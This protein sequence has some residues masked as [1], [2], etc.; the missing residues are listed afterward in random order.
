MG[1][2]FKDERTLKLL[3]LCGIGTREGY[4]FNPEYEEKILN[5]DMEAFD[6]WRLNLFFIDLFS[7][8]KE[9]TSITLDTMKYL[10]SHF[11]NMIEEEPPKLFRVEPKIT[12]LLT[13]TK[14]LLKSKLNP[15]FNSFFLDCD[16]KIKIR[17]QTARIFGMFV[18]FVSVEEME[19]INEKVQGILSDKEIK[20]KIQDRLNISA[21]VYKD[22]VFLFQKLKYD[23]FTGKELNELNILISALDKSDYNKIRRI[24]KEI[25]AFVTN[26]LLFLNEPRVT[27]YL[28]EEKNNIRRTKK[29]KIPIPTMIITKLHYTLKDYIEKIHYSGQGQNKL[30][31]SFWVRGHWR[32]LLSV[33][34]KDIGSRIWIPPYT[35][36]K[37]VLVP[38]L[39]RIE[40]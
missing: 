12:D 27:I 14:P 18:D 5:L 4:I 37:G 15:P 34:Y 39:F 11:K 13:H 16:F 6:S 35:K 23:V 32:T 36:G 7:R 25:T 3:E 10:S 38:Q 8:V 31:Y 9:N 26:V 28:E 2:N 40:E 1:Y 17:D 24:N 21:L 33:R 20:I 29:G 19:K 22:G 30:D